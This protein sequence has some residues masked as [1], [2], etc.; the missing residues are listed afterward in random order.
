M[1]GNKKERKQQSRQGTRVE[2]T[3]EE[4]RQR[5]DEGKQQRRGK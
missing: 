5:V 1:R 2:E 4:R 3:T